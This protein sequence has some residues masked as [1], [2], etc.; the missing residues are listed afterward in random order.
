MTH[1]A[2]LI[3]N[4]QYQDAGIAD[5]RFAAN[6]ALG[7]GALLQETMNYCCQVRCDA[8]VGDLLDCVDN[9]RSRS[10]PRDSVMVY[11][12]GH[13]LTGL[14][15]VHLVMRE[16]RSDLLSAGVYA[17]VPGL[18]SLTALRVLMA[19]LR[20]CHQ[21]VV[22]DACR[23]QTFGED[24]SRGLGS[25]SR[26]SEEGS[27]FRDILKRQQGRVGQAQAVLHG[28]AEGARAIEVPALRHGL[29]TACLMQHL[30][31]SASMK[32]RVAVD[33]A[34]LDALENRMRVAKDSLPERLRRANGRP[35]LVDSGKT[36]FCLY[37][38]AR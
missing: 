20:G 4:N 1:H 8:T 2:I 11:F 26:Q 19:G 17:G 31:D 10:K 36:P 21:L 28:C 38:P 24:G 25:N 12:A 32:L 13:S 23:S 16:A 3:G 33:S 5:L 35:V 18:L 29:F 37:L 9:T 34:L 30:Q 22:L 14:N 7:L 6:D 15:D 27:L